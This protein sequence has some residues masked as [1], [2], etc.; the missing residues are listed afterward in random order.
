M[1]Q[2]YFCTSG[3]D[4]LSKDD[5][6]TCKNSYLAF[7]KYRAQTIFTKFTGKHN[8]RVLF[9][10]VG[11]LKPATVFCTARNFIKKKSHGTN[12]FLWILQN[13]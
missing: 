3:E 2:I 6:K 12:A 1:L 7:Y 8:T 10:R 5:V 13:F 9:N 4:S 11:D